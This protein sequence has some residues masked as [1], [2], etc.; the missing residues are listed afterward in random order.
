MSIDRSP[1]LP[2]ENVALLRG[3]NVGGKNKLP[4]K[5]LAAMFQKAGCDDVRTYIQSG[6]VLF[7]AG[8][9]LTEDIPSLIST[10]ILNGFGYR[11]PVVTRTAL[12]LQEVIRA[13][14]F[15]GAGESKQAS[16]SSFS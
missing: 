5:G 8:P 4:M 12:E 9:S 10:S 7:R 13:N 1:N 14:P 6:N 16:C 3:I 15:V 2:G 11:T